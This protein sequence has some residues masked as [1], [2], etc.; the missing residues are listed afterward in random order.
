MHKQGGTADQSS[1]VIGQRFYLEQGPTT[2]RAGGE[3]TTKKGA[4]CLVPVGCWQGYSRTGWGGVGLESS[5]MFPL[6][7]GTFTGGKGMGAEGEKRSNGERQGEYG[8][9]DYRGSGVVVVVA[10]VL[11]L[12][13][14]FWCSVEIKLPLKKPVKPIPVEHPPP[15]NHERTKK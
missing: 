1:D 5:S 4:K 12:S 6:G 13:S 9:G 3:E 14:T 8:D 2:P 10:V 7:A 11:V 15:T